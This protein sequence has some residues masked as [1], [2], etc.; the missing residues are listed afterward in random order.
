M[1]KLMVS[2][3]LLGLIACGGRT[4]R[5]S[6]NDDD[7]IM[8]TGIESADVESMERFAKSLLAH[9]DLT[10]PGVKGVPTL[11]IWPV[12]NNTRFDFDG[13]LF[14]RRI[15][16][17]LIK[18]AAGRVR[19][20]TRSQ[21]DQEIIAAERDAKRSGEYTSSKK[22]TKTGADF[23]LTGTAAAI[24]KAGHGRESDAIWIDF[25]L[26]DSET[27]DLL[28]EDKFATKK[29]GKAGVVYR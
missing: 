23:Y 16:Q 24:S 14:V 13:E 4:K 9:P 22:T 8:G 28:W 5:V 21:M 2:M 1:Q 7:E 26:I 12:E 15:R 6:I 10:G 11:A 29:V 25:R 3:C 17:A 20:V 19:F 18:N 27:G